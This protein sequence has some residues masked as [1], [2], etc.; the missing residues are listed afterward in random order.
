MTLAPP[1]PPTLPTGSA[2]LEEIASY[3]ARYIAYPTSHALT[4]H[5]LWIAHTYVLSCFDTTPRIAF[6]SV[7]PGSGKSRALEVTAGL[8]PD[9][10]HTVNASI[11]YLFRKI[12]ENEERP[13]VILWDECDAVFTKRPSEATEEKRSLLNSGYRRGA[14]VGRAVVR[15]K[16]IMTEETP[17]F[18]A[19]ALAGLHDLPDT[20]MTRSI[21][22]RMRRRSRSEKVEPFRPRIVETEATRLCVAL[23]EWAET[24]RPSLQDAFAALPDSISDRNADVWEPLVLIADAA[25]G[26]WPA[27]VRD[28]AA[29]FI[30]EQDMRPATLGTRL[31]GDI[32]TV[33]REHDKMRTTELIHALC[34]LDGAPWGML[35][36][37]NPIT[38]N[39]LSRRLAEYDVPTGNTIR[40]PDGTHKGYARHHFADAWDRYL[41]PLADEE[42]P[43]PQDAPPPET[44]IDDEP[45]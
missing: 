5:V 9:P 38:P 30:G 31:L 15:G 3:L 45:F 24:L 8:V 14:T 43:Q 27:K 4:A 34:D 20:I 22:V 40:L 16:E 23:A 37:G 17:S 19:V 13:P 18:S 29:H 42:H 11:A 39:Y 44:L 28:A 25:A 6:L 41:P 35:L 1:A 2:L 7:E 36:S 10:V 26:E 12:G 21:V 33:L 32:R